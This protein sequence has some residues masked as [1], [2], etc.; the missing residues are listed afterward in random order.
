MK[1]K[2]G[3]YY[4][5]DLCYVHNEEMYEKAVLNDDEVENVWFENTA[6]GDGSYF[7]QTGNTYFVDAGII[8]ICPVEMIKENNDWGVMKP[9]HGYNIVDFPED[10]EVDGD[11]GIFTIGHIVI[12]TVGEEVED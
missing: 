6:Y 2:A 10:F 3:K 12:D 8:G 11:N 1:F 7:D 5:G 4:V 9:G